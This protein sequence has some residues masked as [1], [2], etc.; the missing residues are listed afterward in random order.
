MGF[1]A[2]CS[3]GRI[4]KLREQTNRRAHL[5]TETF[6]NPTLQGND[7]R[8]LSQGSY[9]KLDEDGFVSLKFACVGW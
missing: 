4:T 5:W 9:D 3:I 1:F 7:V 2:Q 6:E 8:G